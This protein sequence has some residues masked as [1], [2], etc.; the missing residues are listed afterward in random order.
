MR[1]TERVPIRELKIIA[2]RQLDPEDVLRK[3]ILSQ[4]DSL[5]KGVFLARVEDWLK[6]LEYGSGHTKWPRTRGIEHDDDEVME[7]P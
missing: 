1:T 6:L 5:P 7:A 2:R 4:P 3:L